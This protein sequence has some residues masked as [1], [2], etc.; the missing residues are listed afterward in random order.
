MSVCGDSIFLR[1]LIN[2]V[3]KIENKQIKMHKDD[4][5]QCELRTLSSELKANVKI[6]MFLLLEYRRDSH[7][8]CESVGE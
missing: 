8:L 2:L 4:H 6:G 3:A 1:K 5:K 7:L